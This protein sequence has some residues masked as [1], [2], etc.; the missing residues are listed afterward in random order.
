MPGAEGVRRAMG[1]D[2][3]YRQGF[4]FESLGELTVFLT[5]EQIAT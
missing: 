2:T 5:Y 4:L 3:L 1:G